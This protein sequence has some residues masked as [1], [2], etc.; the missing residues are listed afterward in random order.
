VK[1][2]E[3]GSDAPRD[4]MK[5]LLPPGDDVDDWSVIC[6]EC[7]TNHPRDRQ[8]SPATLPEDGDSR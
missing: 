8:F 7:Q 2:D 6:L 1:C 3:C 5:V 4:E